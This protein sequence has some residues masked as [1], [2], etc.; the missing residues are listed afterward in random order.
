M[1]VC[2]FEGTPFGVIFKGTK[3]KQL[4]I[5]I[6][7][8]TFFWTEA[9]PLLQRL[10]ILAW[11]PAKGR[12]PLPFRLTSSRLFCDTPSSPTS[13][14][15][16]RA[17]R[18]IAVQA[19]EHLGGLQLAAVGVLHQGD[20]ICQGLHDVPRIDSCEGRGLHFDHGCYGL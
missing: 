10:P 9:W 16:F 4:Q 6:L 15:R 20:G 18:G 7:R 8:Q 3:G 5:P 2:K 1:R 17:I 13:L 12:E 11:F 14:P 19:F